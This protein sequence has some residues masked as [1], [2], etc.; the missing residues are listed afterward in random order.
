M[1]TVTETELP[2]VGVRFDLEATADTASALPNGDGF[3][4]LF[5]DDRTA[6]TATGEQLLDSLAERMFD[7]SDLRLSV[8]AYAGGSPATASRARLLSLE[9]GLAVRNYLF[10]RGVRG[11][12][13]DVRALGNTSVDGPPER[14]DLLLVN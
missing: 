13:I 12:R 5:T 2:G 4:I 7:H 6:L 14:V 10:D 9:R 3:R 11:S 8:Q 1:K